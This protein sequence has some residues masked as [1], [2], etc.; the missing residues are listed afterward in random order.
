MNAELITAKKAVSD[1][2]DGSSILLGGFGVIQGWPHE[3]LLAL[4]N[5]GARNLT[6]ICNSPGFGPLSPQILAENGQISKL[7]ASF[8]GYSYRTTVLSDQ[9]SAGMV[10]FEMVPQGT[11]VERIRAGGAGIR[12]FFTPAGIGTLAEE[13]KEKRVF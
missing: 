5:H 1:I 9:I 12:A 2:R 3:L 6:L 13:K 4:R 11:L 10:D 8:G 7:V